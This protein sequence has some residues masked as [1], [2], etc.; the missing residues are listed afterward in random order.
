MFAALEGAFDEQDGSSSDSE[1]DRQQEGAAQRGAA[2]ASPAETDA[3]DSDSEGEGKRR[4]GDNLPRH[5][6]WRPELTLPGMEQGTGQAAGAATAAAAGVPAAAVAVH[7]VGR[8]G[9]GLHVAPPDERELA[10]AARKAA[11]DT[12]GRGWFDLPATQITEEVKQDLRMLRL[13]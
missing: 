12:A 13:R 5:L 6:R 10:R 3:S 11:P 4:A 9:D 2:A 8:G 1:S 7:A